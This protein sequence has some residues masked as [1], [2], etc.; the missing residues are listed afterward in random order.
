MWFLIVPVNYVDMLWLFLQLVVKL[1]IADSKVD[2]ILKK[3]MYTGSFILLA[4][5][6]LHVI[7]VNNENYYVSFSLLPKKDLLREEVLYISYR[8]S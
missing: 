4:T 2:T 8:G 1:F 3:F 7:P 6:T 5:E